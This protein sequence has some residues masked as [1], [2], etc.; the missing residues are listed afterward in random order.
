MAGPIGG[1]ERTG[2]AV[3]LVPARRQTA[4]QLPKT[5]SA[6]D[7][8]QSDRSENRPPNGI[9]ILSLMNAGGGAPAT[10]RNLDVLA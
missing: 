1:P 3:G 7:P 6:R 2:G 8:K 5:L 9:R 10:G 4:D